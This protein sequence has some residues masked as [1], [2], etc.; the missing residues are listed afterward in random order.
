MEEQLA[1]MKDVQADLK[2]KQQEAPGGAGGPAAQG[3]HVMAQMLEGI[4]LALTSVTEGDVDES[5][6]PA[7][8]APEPNKS[9]ARPAD[10]E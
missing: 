6:P 7:S 8:G 1:Y 3:L 4:I 10:V 5:E 9:E 2:K